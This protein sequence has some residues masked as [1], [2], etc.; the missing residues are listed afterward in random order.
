[1]ISSSSPSTTTPSPLGSTNIDYKLIIKVIIYLIIIVS[2]SI[3]TLQENKNKHV[4]LVVVT[5]LS[6]MIFLGLFFSF[7]KVGSA[8]F[9][10]IQLILILYIIILMVLFNYVDKDFFNKYAYYIFPFIFIIGIYL[11]YK[12]L[13]A[14]TDTEKN[15]LVKK[16]SK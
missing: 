12:S 10:P 8:M 4:T 15:L 2:L 6:T 1:M 16:L 11:F 14:A 5:F 7:F 3:S 13:R 9:K